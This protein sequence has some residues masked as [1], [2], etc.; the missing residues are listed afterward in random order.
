VNDN[1]SILTNFTGANVYIRQVGVAPGAEALHRLLTLLSPHATENENTTFKNGPAR[2]ALEMLEQAE[3]LG[4]LQLRIATDLSSTCFGYG[5]DAPEPNPHS[6]NRTRTGVFAV[7]AASLVLVLGALLWITFR[8][9]KKWQTAMQAEL[10]A[11]ELCEARDADSLVRR[12]AAAM[13]GGSLKSSSVGL[14]EDS[15]SASTGAS[16]A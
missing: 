5:P 12:M 4:Q 14:V 8:L 3:A 16:N 13:M 15:M 7:V 9:R 10:V 1:T 11:E 6:D 2:D